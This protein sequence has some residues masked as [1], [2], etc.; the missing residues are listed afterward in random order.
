[1]L[2]K[3]SLVQVKGKGLFHLHPDFK[4]TLTDE[5]G[6]SRSSEFFDF[7]PAQG[8]VYFRNFRGGNYGIRSQLKNSPLRRLK[9]AGIDLDAERDRD[10]F[11]KL[12]STL[13][14]PD[15]MSVAAESSSEPTNE[16]AI[17]ARALK[18]L[19]LRYNGRI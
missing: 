1:M 12:V 13:N 2:K 8:A 18:S 17:V 5:S 15:P 10:E 7:S 9:Q 4:I 19:I 16:T 11:A 3:A 14:L 6:N